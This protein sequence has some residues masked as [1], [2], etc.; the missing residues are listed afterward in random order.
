MRHRN[1]TGR[2]RTEP[3]HRTVLGRIKVYWSFWRSHCSGPRGLFARAARYDRRSQPNE[4]PKSYQRPVARQG[5]E[6]TRD[7]RRRS[8]MRTYTDVQCE[9]PSLIRHRPD[10][11]SRGATNWGTATDSRHSGNDTH[12][13]AQFGCQHSKRVARTL[14]SCILLWLY[15]TPQKWANVSV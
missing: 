12:E 13:L 9:G 6:Q 15:A 10:R 8:R 1:R 3:T 5:C 2:N 4:E 11:D 14:P 7:R